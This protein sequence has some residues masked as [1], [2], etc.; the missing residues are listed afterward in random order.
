MGFF[1]KL[2]NAIVRFMYGRNGM[3][4]MNRALF[5]VYIALWL[6]GSILSVMGLDVLSAIFNVVLY[7]L[8]VVIVFRMFSKNL[9][10]RREENSKFLQKTWKIRS[11]IGGGDESIVRLAME[12]E[13]VMVTGQDF[14][15]GST[16]SAVTGL[17]GVSGYIPDASLR[18]I[19]QEE[20]QYYLDIWEDAH[21]TAAPTDTPAPTEV[22]AQYTG[23]A[24]TTEAVALRTEVSTAD[25]SIIRRMD[26]N[27][28]VMLTGQSFEQG[29]SWSLATTLDNVSGYVP[30]S[31]LRRIN[32]EEAQYYINLWNEAHP[33]ETPSPAPATPE[34][35]KISGYAYAVGDDVYF[36]SQPSTMASIIDVLTQGVVVYVRDQDYQDNVAWHVVQYNGQWGYIRADMLRM[37]TVQEEMPTWTACLLPNLPPMLP[38]SPMIPKACPA[39]A[40]CP[41]AR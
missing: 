7:V 37:M 34:P 35:A 14:S 10:K 36:R 21:A 38:P 31:S 26:A 29:A 15:T 19:N 1:R 11:Q 20:A 32:N 2:G 27:E 5:W 6:A 13:L 8:L 24:L 33:T 23:Y 41:I 4:Q 40:M 9:Y 30:D 3:D 18:H 12:K 25:S 16:W 22:P 39:T 28:L 17:D